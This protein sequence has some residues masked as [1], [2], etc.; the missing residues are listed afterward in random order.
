MRNTIYFLFGS[1]MGKY[2]IEGN[3]I[4]IAAV[5]AAAVLLLCILLAAM[6]AGKNKRLAEISRLKRQKKHYERRVYINET[7]I[8][9][10]E[11]SAESKESRQAPEAVRKESRAAA[12]DDFVILDESMPAGAAV[13]EKMEKTGSEKIHVPAAEQKPDKI[14]SRPARVCPVDEKPGMIENPLKIPDVPVKSEMGYD[15]S[16]SDDDDYDIKF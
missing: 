5:C 13:E 1:E 11:P 12:A 4:S 14:Q 6:S 7:D 9:V 2:L 15:I 10:K 16:V 8:Q 3:Y